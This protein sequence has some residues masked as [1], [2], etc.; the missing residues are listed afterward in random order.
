[1]SDLSDKLMEVATIMTPLVL[2]ATFSHM[3]KPWEMLMGGLLIPVDVT[4]K[5]KPAKITYVP[6]Y[7][8]GCQGVSQTQIVYVCAEHLTNRVV[9]R[10][11]PLFLVPP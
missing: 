1:M 9:L 8:I 6:C 4:H 2:D 10:D 5:S 3:K 7:L 11:K